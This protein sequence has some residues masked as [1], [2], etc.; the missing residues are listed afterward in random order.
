LI[1]LLD[2][3]RWLS[4]QVHP[5]DEQAEQLEGPGYFGKTEAWY[6][7]EAGRA[8][9]LSA[10]SVPGDPGRYPKCDWKESYS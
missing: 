9:N 8:L 3:A 1:K 7:V 2:C 10:V 6:V 5:N 4:L